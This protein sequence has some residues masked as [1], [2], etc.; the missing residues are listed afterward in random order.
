MDYSDRTY[1][2]ANIADIDNVDFSH[3]MDPK[4]GNS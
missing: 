1:A 4:C 3:V 2:F